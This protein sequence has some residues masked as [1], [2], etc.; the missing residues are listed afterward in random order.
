MTP[1]PAPRREVLPLWRGGRPARHGGEHDELGAVVGAELEHRPA[2][3][4]LGRGGADDEPLGD[5]GVAEAK[6]DEP[7]DLAFAWSQ[8]VE[9][10]GAR[11][12]R[13]WDGCE[14]GDQPTREAWRQHRVAAGEELDRPDELGRFGVLEDQAAGAGAQRGKDALVL[15]GG[16]QQHHRDARVGEHANRGLHG[17]QPR[18]RGVEEHDIGP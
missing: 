5:V 2:D 9:Q 3:V 14:L 18:Q 12:L 8:L 1:P 13:V 6:R 16:G 10:I 11:Q 4:G 15:F 7:H 17:V